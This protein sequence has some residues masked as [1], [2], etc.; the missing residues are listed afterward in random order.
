MHGGR[1]HG[2]EIC[3]VK[4]SRRPRHTRGCS[5]KEELV[6]IKWTRVTFDKLIILKVVKP[7]PYFFFA[8][9]VSLP[10]SQVFATGPH[11]T[12]AES[13]PYLDAPFCYRAF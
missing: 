12:P 7:V 13:I 3:G 5:A 10:C 8:S 4:S 6:V 2:I 1:K 9:G 11:P